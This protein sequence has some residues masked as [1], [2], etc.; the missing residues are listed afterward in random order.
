MVNIL[1]KPTLDKKKAKLFFQS[2]F[3]Q[4]LGPGTFIV[5]KEKHSDRYF[6]TETQ[7]QVIKMS[8]FIMKER[9]E[10]GWYECDDDLTTFKLAKKVIKE[11]DG[12][13]AFTVLWRD[14]DSEYSGFEITKFEESGGN[15]L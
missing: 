11:K 7:E 14:R 2:Y 13:A 15:R 4:L 5:F 12:V 10:E 8:L 6:K 9:L 1:H 3:K